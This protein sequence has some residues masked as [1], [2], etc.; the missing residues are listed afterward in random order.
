MTIRGYNAR[1]KPVC[2]KAQSTC[3]HYFLTP[4]K[5]HTVHKIIYEIT[6]YEKVPPQVS[7]YPLF[8]RYTWFTQTKEANLLQHSIDTAYTLAH[9]LLVLT[10]DKIMYQYYNVWKFQ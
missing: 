10:V 6:I 1:A 2:T 4:W 9:A 3:R 7:L 5:L 8:G